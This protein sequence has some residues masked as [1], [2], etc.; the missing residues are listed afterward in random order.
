MAIFTPHPRLSHAY[1]FLPLPLLT[2]LVAKPDQLVKRRGKHGLIKAG[3]DYEVSKQWINER[4]DKAI[5]VC[6]LCGN[7][8]QKRRVVFPTSSYKQFIFRGLPVAIS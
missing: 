7:D 3:V 8:H 6:V 4:M 2:Q 1:S 5:L